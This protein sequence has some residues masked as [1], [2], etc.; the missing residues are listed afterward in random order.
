M[1]QLIKD[2]PEQILRAVEIGEK[3]TL[4]TKF[5][6]PIKNIVV[7]GLGGS[8]IGGNLLGELLRE[9]L[10]I[11]VVVNKGYQLPAFVD[12]S[13][14]LILCS[15]SGNTEE[16]VSC[17][18]QALAKG[19]KPV[20]ITSGGKLEDIAVKNA[21]DLIK[22]PAGFPPRCCLGYSATQLFFVLKHYG[23]IDGEFK[24]SL[25]RVASFL[26]VEQH[27]IMTEAE[28]LANKVV[29]RVVIAYADEK[30]E[31]TVLRLKQQINENSKMHCWHNVVP[32]LN[33]NELVGWRERNDNLAILFFRASDEY[34]RNTH[35]LEFT[36]EVVKSVSHNV[37][38]VHALGNDTFE[39][40]F[41]LIHFGDWLSYYLGIQQGYDPTEI[42][43]LIKLKNHM[44]S[45]VD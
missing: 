10:S 33:H 5:D 43:V 30:Y 34:K 31:S 37:H 14:L 29:R 15:Y 16:T 9:D 12:A 6:G 24:D 45:I 36:K 35:R 42:E 3:A 11:P 25:I 26:E 4:N 18:N 38:E 23:L 28:V 32:E 22:I 21:L 41:F 20:C 40:H 8:G 17:A 19:L 27:K 13:T 44:G 1:Y 2:F 7:S 39:K